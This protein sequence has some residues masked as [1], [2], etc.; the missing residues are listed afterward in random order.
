[1]DTAQQKVKGLAR[2]YVYLPPKDWPVGVGVPIAGQIYYDAME[3][4]PLF[5]TW[6]KFLL[7][8]ESYELVGVYYEPPRQ[9]WLLIVES[10]DIAPPPR[11]EMLPIITGRYQVEYLPEGRR[12]S[13]VDFV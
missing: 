6:H 2:L 9:S 4:K 11:G 8:P 3:V 1:M 13:F 12:V 7:L 5:D 10:E